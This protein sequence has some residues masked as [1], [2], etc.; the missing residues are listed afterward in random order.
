MSAHR[1]QH[2]GESPPRTAPAA[3]RLLA[4]TLVAALVAPAPARADWTK[5]EPTDALALNLPADI[6]ITAG[7]FGFWLATELA[8][9]KLAP[10]NCR[11]CNG[12]D[13]SG[14]AIDP[15]SGQGDL[16][17]VDAFFHDQLTG[18]LWSRKT[19]DTVSNVLGFAAVPVG[20]LA[21][22]YFATGEHGSGAGLRGVLIV[23]ESVAVSG[24]LIQ[25]VKLLAA[26]KRPFVRYGHATDGSTPDEGATYDVNNLDSHASFPSGHTGA[27]AAVTFSAAMVASLQGSASAPYLWAGAVLCT[28]SVGALRMM[29]EKHYFTDVLGGAAIGAA[30]GVLVPLLHRKGS[31]LGTDTTAALQ[32]GRSG[33]GTVLAVSGAF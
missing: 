20:A 9:S 29:A 21:A 10:A 25:T 5:A 17:G 16:N 24:A 2:R 13:N 23:A 4:A 30:S 14:F 6:A 22:A 7:G 32:I 31:A 12:S 18:A 15:R 19:S 1:P 8:K 11:I 33:G 28:A 27:T 3:A 26:R